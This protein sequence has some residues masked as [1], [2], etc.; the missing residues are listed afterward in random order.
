METELKVCQSCGMQLGDPGMYATNSDESRNEDYCIYCYA[1]GE[2]TEAMTMDEM[3]EHCAD[4]V[5]EYNRH[6]PEPV[7]REESVERMKEFF[8]KLKRWAKG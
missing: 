3:I 8:P 2:F 4:L 5:E 7:T 1:F 6:A